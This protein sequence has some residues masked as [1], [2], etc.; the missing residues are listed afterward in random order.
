MYVFVFVFV[1]VNRYSSLK[2]PR[3]ALCRAEVVCA[4]KEVLRCA[5]SNGNGGIVSKGRIKLKIKV[6]HESVRNTSLCAVFLVSCIGCYQRLFPFLH[7]AVRCTFY[8]AG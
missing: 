1:Y 4:K 3:R 6:K 7:E 5:L 2:T 8:I